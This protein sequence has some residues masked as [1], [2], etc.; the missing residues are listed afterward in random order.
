MVLFI[1]GISIALYHLKLD[2]YEDVLS[3]TE[4]LE[5]VRKAKREGNTFAFN[6]KVRDKVSQKLWGREPVQYCQNSFWNTVKCRFSS[7]LM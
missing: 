5:A 6:L 7:S 2:Y 1:A 4:Y 3:G